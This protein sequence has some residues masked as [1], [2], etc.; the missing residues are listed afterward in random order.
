MPLHSSGLEHR[1]QKHIKAHVWA[2]DHTQIQDSIW[3]KIPLILDFFSNKDGEGKAL[4]DAKRQMSV[5][6]EEGSDTK[7]GFIRTL[8]QKPF[9]ACD[10][11][12]DITHSADPKVR[13][14][15]YFF[16]PVTQ[17]QLSIK[18]HQFRYFY[19]LHFIY[20]QFI[21]MNVKEHSCLSLWCFLIIIIIKK[22][23]WN[24]FFLCI[25]L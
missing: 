16:F 1:E 8:V 3:K 21:F 7:K 13:Q 20:S 17:S 14:F 9:L 22:N 19:M 25:F 24:I 6:T 4:T 11:H 15:F 2:P 18:R 5:W 10:P 12:V 23:S